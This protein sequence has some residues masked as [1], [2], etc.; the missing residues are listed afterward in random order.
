VGFEMKGFDAKAYHWMWRG[1][2]GICFNSANSNV[3]E[4]RRGCPYC[5]HAPRYSDVLYLSDAIV[6]RHV[7]CGSA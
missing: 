5:L 6:H 4:Y 2:E 7:G 3:I 1:A